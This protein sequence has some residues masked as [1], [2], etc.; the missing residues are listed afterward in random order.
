MLIELSGEVGGRVGRYEIDDA[1]ASGFRVKTQ[2]AGEGVS[3]VM[4]TTREIQQERER[5][6]K[7]ESKRERESKRRERTR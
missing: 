5:K 3:E 4:P 6:R 7:R 1:Q 2:G